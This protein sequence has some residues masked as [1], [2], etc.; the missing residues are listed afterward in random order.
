MHDTNPDAELIFGR[1]PQP[2]DST[3]PTPPAPTRANVI[4]RA[5]YGD[6]P[7][8]GDG[9]L[10][11]PATS[12]R[13]ALRVEQDE[14]RDVGCSVEELREWNRNAVTV[15]HSTGLPAPFMEQVV[16]MH[17][18]AIKTASRNATDTP[19]A[20]QPQRDAEQ[21]RREARERYGDR[22]ERLLQQV[23][24]FVSRHAGL[25]TMLETAG[26]RHHPRVVEGLLD[27][28]RNL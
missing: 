25:R 15:M 18:S 28:V 12:L 4:E 22:A 20:T 9:Q 1:D 8:P 2:H 3:H 10:E 5:L 13:E 23:D 6:A 26:I 27:H 21:S 16:R 14:L 11:V 24:T 7:L 19:D 17:A